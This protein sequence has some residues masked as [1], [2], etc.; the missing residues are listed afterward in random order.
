MAHRPVR[1]AA[2]PVRRCGRWSRRPS[3]QR[4]GGRALR[5]RVGGLVRHRVARMHAQAHAGRHRH[6]RAR[7]HTGASTQNLADTR[8]HA[9]RMQTRMRTN[10]QARAHKRQLRGTARRQ[11]RVADEN[12]TPSSC[13]WDARESGRL[14]LLLVCE[15]PASRVRRTRRCPQQTSAGSDVA[16]ETSGVGP[17]TARTM[18]R[19]AL[20][21]QRYG[22]APVGG[23]V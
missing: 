12:R 7:V 6:A 1:A 22:A 18:D 10:T 5:M 21:L 17:A 15:P 2:Y 23:A 14:L 19:L 4:S 16:R 20:A 9:A 3:K 13:L 11:Q 8:T